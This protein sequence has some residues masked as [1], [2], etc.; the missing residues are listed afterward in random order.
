MSKWVWVTEMDLKGK[1]I[2]VGVTG[3]I[4]IYKACELVSQLRQQGA[5]V[6][7]LMTP[8]ATRLISPLT[9]HALSGN[10]V[11]TDLFVPETHAIEHVALADRA[12]AFLI[13]PATANTIAKLALGLA[14]DAVTTTALACPAPLVIAP[15]METKMWQH[16]ATQGHIKTL[17]ARGVIIVEPETGWL[18][19]G[20][21]G[22][23]RLAS[24]ERILA[25]LRE[26]LKRRERGQ[27]LAGWR[28][29]V[30]AGATRE[31]FDPVRFISN[32]STGKMGIAV[33]QA[34]RERG[35]E[36]VLIAGHTEAPLPDGVEIVQ[37][38]T[39][40][41][42]LDAVLRYADWLEVFVGAAAVADFTPKQVAA[43]K[44][45]R[46]ETERLLLELEPTADILMA[47]RQRHPDAFLVGFAAE[48]GEPLEKA[49]EKLAHKGLDMIVANDVSQP[50]AGFG[51]DTNRCTFITMDGQ[52]KTLPLLTKLEVAHQLW[53]FV[54]EC[55]RRF[56]PAA[57]G[58]C[59]KSHIGRRRTAMTES[60]RRRTIVGGESHRNHEGRS[61]ECG[62]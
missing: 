60:G 1:V 34:A 24:L 19:S 4:A 35:A 42:M 21:Q 32:P 30:T 5:E 26:A 38:C 48:V 6:H 14:D 28:V 8:H 29:V 61:F 33:A 15:A 59:G 23:G 13:A 25:A 56:M 36:V 12:D 50:D 17:Q 20:K 52:I 54:K 55:R 18:A 16:P 57:G 41:E 40:K 43:T 2:L 7:V 45:R 31:F 3:S 39:A 47:L 53:D 46:S 37:V 44:L 22:V 58:A 49:K 10:P 62:C 27:D 11:V 51:A 9:F